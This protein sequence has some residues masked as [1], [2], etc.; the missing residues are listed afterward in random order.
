[1][2]K[3]L[4]DID[5]SIEKSEFDYLK[6]EANLFLKSIKSAIKQSKI[7]AEPF[8]G[9]S[10]AKNTM[11]RSDNYDIDVFIRF[12]KKYKEEELSTL[13]EKIAK[14]LRMKLN[15]L[16]GSR[17]YLQI[18]KSK[19]L[20]FE[21]IPVTKINNPKEAKNTT[22]LSYFHVNYVKN[23][24][25]KNKKL[26]KEI[27]LAKKFFKAQ[28]VYGAESYIS[29]FSGYAVECLIIH[30]K[31]F[32]KMIKSFLT[33]KKIMIDEENQFKKGNILIEINEAKTQS[34]IVLVDPTFKERNVLAAL[35]NET[36][37]KLKDKIKLFLKRPSFVYFEVKPMNEL[38]LQDE[39][40]KEKLEFAKIT[41]STDKQAGDIAGT[42]L[43]KF[44]RY[45]ISEIKEYFD[46]RKDEF[47]YKMSQEATL[48][49]ILKSKKEILK[50]GPPIRKGMEKH[51]L[52]FKKQNKKY[53]VKDGNLYARIPIKFT[54]K[55]FIIDFA[56]D[57]KKKL[58][59]MDVTELNV[60]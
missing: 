46:I 21:V 37:D 7:K 8:I 54:A 19:K 31:S 30:Y 55:D 5:F 33:D 20:T 3:L 26:V 48:Y 6:Y 34:P 32:E 44:S 45:L 49:L 52:A 36:F 22:D 35:S 23:K 40:K 58:S 43:K 39:A 29:G 51:I 15:K 38:E 1:M 4:E 28:K 17:D 47:E 24:I 9:G 41:L 56:K 18:E 12:D 25:R 57:N 60:N 50:C 2:I 53:F 42:K 14:N 59:E 13:L 16:H 10:F 27:G 11:I